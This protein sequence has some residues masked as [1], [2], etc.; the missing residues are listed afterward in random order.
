MSSYSYPLSFSQI[1]EQISETPVLSLND[2]LI[3]ILKEK[4]AKY[5]ELE[6]EKRNQ[7]DTQVASESDVERNND[8]PEFENENEDEDDEDENDEGENDEDE[9]E[10]ELDYY[11]NV[12]DF[13]TSSLTESC[14]DDAVR[15]ADS[16][17]SYYDIISDLT[18]KLSELESENESLNKKFSEIEADS[19]AF[20]KKISESNSKLVSPDVYK[21]MCNI[22]KKFSTI[23]NSHAANKEI[24]YE[25][26][27]N[28]NMQ[29][30]CD[31]LLSDSSEKY[32]I[33]DKRSNTGTTKITLKEYMFETLVENGLG[34]LVEDLKNNNDNSTIDLYQ[35]IILDPTIKQRKCSDYLTKFI[36]S[37]EKEIE[38]CIAVTTTN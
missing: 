34:D 5:E 11:Y 27:K 15:V 21:A 20:D 30:I 32:Y 10:V 2:N 6:L 38:Q 29:T 18:I 25:Q 35:Q 19:S 14:V 8:I 3:Q 23:K 26:V 24:I 16:N 4:I 33:V 1:V 13:N 28:A 17:A 9:N 7:V 37:N 22:I 36:Q 12:Q 31:E